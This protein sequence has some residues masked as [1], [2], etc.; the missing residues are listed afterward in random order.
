MTSRHKIMREL[1]LIK[2]FGMQTMIFFNHHKSI[3]KNNIMK[4][5]V[6]LLKWLLQI[7]SGPLG[8]VNGYVNENFNIMS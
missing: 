1:S 7:T 3:K 6:L 8:V 5:N 4:S 2:P